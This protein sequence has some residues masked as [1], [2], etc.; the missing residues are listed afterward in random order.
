[1]HRRN[2]LSRSRTSRR[3][4]SINRWS[5]RSAKPGSNSKSYRR[6]SDKPFRIRTTKKPKTSK[7]PSRTTAGNWIP[8]SQRTTGTVAW[9]KTSLLIT[10]STT[11]IQMETK[12]QLMTSTITSLSTQR[13]MKSWTCQR[14]ITKAKYR[15]T[16]L[17]DPIL[18]SRS[19]RP[20]S[21]EKKRKNPT[22][23][24]KIESYPH[25]LEELINRRLKTLS[26]CKSKEKTK[27][28]FNF[29]K[30]TASSFSLQ[31]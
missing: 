6:L 16:E 18:G 21:W 25:S 31:L 24:I 7:I 30:S 17:P 22:I 11:I 8:S 26:S 29:N 15:I 2:A 9:R 23:T 28:N 10:M 5:R 1:M 4:T 14:W 13:W 27:F 3:L 12:M 20:Y 19:I